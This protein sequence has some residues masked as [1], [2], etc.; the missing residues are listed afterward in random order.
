MSGPICAF[1]SI[2][3]SVAC[4]AADEP[5]AEFWFSSGLD[6]GASPWPPRRLCRRAA[7]CYRRS[8]PGQHQLA[9]PG[10]LRR[11]RS[12]ARRAA[13]RLQRGAHAP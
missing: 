10:K 5:L 4:L 11:Q 2:V 9:L 13:S 6:H 7:P 1:L 12:E 8:L 3:F